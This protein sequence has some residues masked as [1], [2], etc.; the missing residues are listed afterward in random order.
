MHTDAIAASGAGTEVSTRYVLVAAPR[1]I[2]EG[3]AI[4]LLL[5][6]LERRGWQISEVPAGWPRAGAVHRSKHV[7]LEMGS[8]EAFTSYADLHSGVGGVA[9]RAASRARAFE[10]RALIEISL[11]PI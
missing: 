11:T 1:G 9:D 10:D 2:G 7:G 4:P 8:F 3:D 5:S 6:M